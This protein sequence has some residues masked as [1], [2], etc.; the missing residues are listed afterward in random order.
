[1]LISLSTLCSTYGIKDFGVLHIGAH[2]AEERDSYKECGAS[3]V[4]WIEA[5]PDLAAHIDNMISENTEVFETEV[6]INLAAFDAD[7]DEVDFN[8][9]SST[10]SS[11]LLDFGTHSESH[12]EIKMD[13]KIAVATK[14]I[15]SLAR[16]RP[17]L[18]KDI[19]FATL[20]IQGAEHAALKGFGDILKQF[21]W[22][23]AEVNRREVYK[24]NGMIWDIDRLLL[25]Y[26][27]FRKQTHFTWESWGDAFYEK[28]AHISSLSRLAYQ[29]R[30]RL[31]YLIWAVLD[32]QVVRFSIRS[33]RKIKHSIQYHN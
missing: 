27:F 6:V 4:V 7:D 1:M 12:P 19:D 21:K 30:L 29:T 16:E 32:L 22:V 20:D 28:Q 2:K 13:H 17:H 5:N 25:Q 15:D 3:K 11:S 33:L 9:S 10:G 8:V 23:Y 14:R 26:G 24:G 18:F 31:Q